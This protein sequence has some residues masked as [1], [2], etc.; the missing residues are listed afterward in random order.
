MIVSPY[1]PLFFDV[2]R[3]DGLPSS[4]MQTFATTDRI[5]VEALSSGGGA[6]V[7]VYDE[8]A[9][10]LAFVAGASDW[11]VNADTVLTFVELCMSPGVYSVAVADPASGA[12]RQSEPFCVTD[13]PA[14]LAN[15]VLV[16]YSMKDD[17]QRKD[18]RFFIDRMQRFFDFRVPG[19]FKAGSQSYG[20]ECEQFV[21]EDGDITQSYSLE[22]VQRKFTLGHSMGCPE[23]FGE[24][25]HRILGC[26]YVYFDGVRYARK[27]SNTPE[28]SQPLE[29][30]ASFIFSQTLQKVTHLDP[31]IEERNLALLRR[32]DGGTYRSATTDINRITR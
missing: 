2:D 15:T 20:V 29:G 3:T 7:T 19:G 16:Q 10:T 32:V 21:T 27:D 14:Q 9:H 12:A 28:P 17:R 26:T 25:L 18:C 22:T 4:Y 8:P 5:L 1:T 31:A 30:V 24:K 11:R 23:W 6:T 13:S